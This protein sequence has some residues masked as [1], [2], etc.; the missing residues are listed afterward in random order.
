MALD[1]GMGN[2]GKAGQWVPVG[3]GSANLDDR[4]LDGWGITSLSH[5]RAATQADIPALT[6]IWFNGWMEAHADHVPS[7]LTEIR[8]LESFNTRLNDHLG[9]TI[10]IGPEGAPTGFV[11]VKGDEINQIYVAPEGRGTGA[12]A[13][14]ITAGFDLIHK[15]GHSEA[16]LDVIPQNK[17]AISFYE[18]MGWRQKGIETVLLDTL[19]KP[20]AL[21]CMVMTRSL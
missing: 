17:R 8:T 9:N 20:Y 11:L 5:T 6:E 21:D 18:K 12:A 7:S 14:L 1:P 16:R 15:A 2:C 3:V 13:L 10:T 19:D 4:R